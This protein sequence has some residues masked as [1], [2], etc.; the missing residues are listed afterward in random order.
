[1]YDTQQPCPGSADEKILLQ[2]DGQKADLEPLGRDL[3]HWPTR[4]MFS[5]SE[6]EFFGVRNARHECRSDLIFRLTSRI[7]PG[8]NPPQKFSLRLQPVVESMAFYTSTLVV[9][10][11]S[12]N[13]NSVFEDR[14][15]K[16]RFY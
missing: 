5:I 2:P 4:G 15:G 3:D 16:S 9:Q 10:L 13:A 14:L 12:A 6:A 8:H 1:M 7:I 11:V